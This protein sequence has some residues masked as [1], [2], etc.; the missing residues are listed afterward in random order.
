MAAL[1]LPNLGEGGPAVVR[2]VEIHG[3]GDEYRY[4]LEPLWLTANL[5]G[6]AQMALTSGLT[7]TDSTSPR[8]I[9]GEQVKAFRNVNMLRVQFSIFVPPLYRSLVYLATQLD[10]SGPLVFPLLTS[11]VRLAPGLHFVS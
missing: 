1:S 3:S 11:E 8:D 10:E 5:V 6:E 2:R 9:E 7:R 4:K